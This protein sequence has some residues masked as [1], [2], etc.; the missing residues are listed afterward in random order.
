MALD[1][2]K[3]LVPQGVTRTFRG[4]S[5]GP[6]T[7]RVTA[8]ADFPREGAVT[9]AVGGQGYYAGKGEFTLEP[10]DPLATGLT[11]PGTFNEARMTHPSSR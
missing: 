4:I 2:A 8:P 7:G 1:H 6:F 10:Q 9:I 3:G 11:L 5:G